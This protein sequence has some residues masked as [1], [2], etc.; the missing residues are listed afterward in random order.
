MPQS[1]ANVL[2]HIVF[3][4]KHCQP[5]LKS[6]E[7]REQLNAYMVGTLRNHECLSLIVNCVE[8]HLHCICQLSRKIS[9]AKLLDEMKTDS[10]AWLKTKALELSGFYWQAGYGAFSVS[11]SDAGAVKRYIADQEEHHRRATYQDE[12][13][14]LLRR[15]EIEWDERYVWD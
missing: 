8:D 4:T 3:S 10:S 9:I 15:H 7:I 13:R 14:D 11:Q 2:L 1:L 12:Y 5:F 6:K